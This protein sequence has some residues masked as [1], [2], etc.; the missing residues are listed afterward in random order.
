MDGINFNIINF[1]QNQFLLK[2][3]NLIIF[4]IIYKMSSNYLPFNKIKKIMK[5][6]TD[7]NNKIQITKLNDIISILDGKATLL[8]VSFVIIFVNLFILNY[9]LI[10]LI[11]K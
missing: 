3:I 2:D 8:I 6:T 7:E 10:N 4:I 11:N 1:L 5:E 9:N